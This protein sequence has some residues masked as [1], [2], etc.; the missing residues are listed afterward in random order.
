MVSCG[1][2]THLRRRR[3]WRSRLKI[4]VILSK[5][6]PCGEARPVISSQ[7]GVTEDRTPLSG[8]GPP[9]TAKH[10]GRRRPGP[11]LSVMSKSFP[12]TLGLHFRVQSL[13]LILVGVSR[14][15]LSCLYITNG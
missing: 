15:Y 4:V 13:Y 6:C 11:G 10:R 14:D 9:P 12:S 3:K 7:V 5:E 8:L 2:V 1:S